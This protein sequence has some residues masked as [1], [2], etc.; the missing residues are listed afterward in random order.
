MQNSF[1]LAQGRFNQVKAPYGVSIGHYSSIDTAANSSFSF[2]TVNYIS[3]ANSY[4]LGYDINVTGP[5]SIGLGHSTNVTGSNAIGI[6][7]TASGSSSLAIKGTASGSSSISISG[8]A[9]GTSSTAIRGN[10]T[11]VSALAIGSSTTASGTRSMVVSAQSGSQAVGVSSVAIG[12]AKATGPTSIA[13]GPGINSTGWTEATGL[14]S[15]AIGVG[16]TAAGGK[17]IAIGN[18]VTASGFDSMVLGSNLIAS[19]DG[20]VMIGRTPWGITASVSPTLESRTIGTSKL[21]LFGSGIQLCTGSPSG[22]SCRDEESMFITGA[23]AYASVGIGGPATGNSS[24]P[25]PGGQAKLF[26]QC[27]PTGSMCAMKTD[28]HTTWNILSDKRLKTIEGKYDKGLAEI[29][30]INTVKFRY[31]D[32]KKMGLSS[33]K[34]IVGIVAQEMKKIIPESV[35][36]DERKGY[37]NFTNDAVF[38]AMV[39]AIQEQN[40]QMNKMNKELKKENAALKSRLDAMEE[41]LE[42]LEKK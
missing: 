1:V 8:T 4:A 10:A 25:V 30:K 22:G 11:G 33:E 29:L 27:G 6:S 42:A 18:G 38:W 24:I 14:Q 32:N 21:S 16:A 31:K 34:Q 19:S 26:I 17:S 36:G 23:N 15:V 35:G 2:G 7:G 5:S 20:S 3:A 9:S 39:N 37:L 41:R 13:I 28:G 40:Q 12:G